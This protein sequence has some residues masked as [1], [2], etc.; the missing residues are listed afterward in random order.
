MS[1]ST[2]PGQ[3]VS[4][5]SRNLKNVKVIFTP[6]GIRGEVPEGMPVLRAARR[7]GVDVESICG[8]QGICGTCKVFHVVGDFPKYGVNSTHDSL[9][10]FKEVE[11][12]RVGDERQ[13]G[14]R[15]GCTAK[16]MNDVVIEIPASSQSHEQD[17][18]KAV[19][20]REIS[21]DPAISVFTAYIPAPIMDV[22]TADVSRL[23]LDLQSNHD[24]VGLWYELPIVKQ[25]QSM[26][27]AHLK[28]TPNKSMPVSVAIYNSVRKPPQIVALWTGHEAKAYGAAI[29][30]GSTSIVV[31]LADLTT[32]E[33]VA[34]A[35]AMNP[36]IKFGE[37]LM[38]RVSY[39]MMN[40]GGDVE[41]SS[42]VRQRISD[43]IKE[44]AG[45]VW[46]KA[47]DVMDVV[48]VCNPIMHHI[49]LGLD[50]V[51]LGGAPFNLAVD[52]AMEVA[53]KELDL[54]LHDA[55][56]VF[57]LPCLAG[58]IGADAAGVV[59]SERPDQSDEMTLI[60]D[61]GTNAEIVLGNRNRMLAASSPT[62]PAFEGAQISCGQRAAVG[63][64]E[65][66]RIDRMSLEPTFKIIGC[67]PWSNDPTFEM[68]SSSLKISGI[69]GSG[70]IEII[71]EMFLAGIINRD[72]V[73][74]PQE[75]KPSPRIIQD[76][77]TYSYI[78]HE[79]TR[80]LKITQNDV[81]AIQLAKAALYAG[82]RLLM[83]RMGIDSVERIKLAG[84]FGSRID[85]KYAM[86]LGMIPD[87][88]LQNAGGVGN[89]AGE[90]AR[91]ALLNR[92][93]RNE[94]EPVI[95]RIEK[96]E[97]ATESSFQA[98]FVGAMGFPHSSAPFPNLER[99]IPGLAERRIPSSDSVNASRGRRR[100][101]AR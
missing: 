87:C 97:T 68:S 100:R 51:P 8:G 32:G 26:V 30:L 41:M 71:G 2:Q 7:L 6:S 84:A 42:A 25:L 16:I 55:A 35:S 40:K 65:R 10:E 88:D 77:R 57:L 101:P 43:L 99:V 75:N 94:I 61:V 73:I 96:I 58:H 3:R 20:D 33:V 90:G 44:A 17:I 47:S 18:A 50:P 91:I 12:G 86:L 31:H 59:L 52:Q 89:A 64:I 23:V 54:P 70:I 24:L 37:D 45:Q 5:R 46:M 85:V 19:D 80:Q 67:D 28:Q 34:S 38:S 66:V 14:A 15:L 48:I 79:G 29:D 63:A 82:I 56:R 81:R 93:A 13:L 4:R 69:C 78:L 72:G 36:Q 39:A 21:L 98:H 74:Q 83:D 92:H 9:S 76:G 60:V 49:L 11:A 22:P 1:E 62:G 95:R 53:A 27:T